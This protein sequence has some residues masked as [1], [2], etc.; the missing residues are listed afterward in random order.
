MKNQLRYP[1]GQHNKVHR[2]AE[3]RA[4]YDLETVHSIMNRSFV[5]HVSFQPDAEDP[6]PTT[7][8]MLGAMGNFA[9]PSAGLNEPQDC[10]IHG[11]ISARMANLSRKAMDDGL[12]G[13]PVC[14][15]VAKVDGLVLALSAFTHSCNYRSAVLFGH[16]ALVTD[17][18][19]KLW[20][21]ELLTNKIIPGRWDQVRQPPNKFELMQT[22]IL[23]VRVTSGSA[24]IRAGPPADDKED[25]QD[26]GVM[27]NVWSGYVPLVERMGQPIPSAYNQL[28]DV[29]EHVR[30]LQEGFNEEADAYNDKLVKQA[31]RKESYVG[32]FWLNAAETLI[33]ITKAKTKTDTNTNTQWILEAGT[34]DD[35]G[36]GMDRLKIPCDAIWLDI[37]CPIDKECL[38]MRKLLDAFG[39]KLIIIIDPHF[40]NTN[41]YNIVL[42]SNDITSRSKDDDIFEG[43]C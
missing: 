29:P 24:K 34:L 14:V 40:K 35:L 28:Q 1:A 7:I 12:P 41:G 9:Y 31:N 19:E 37:E 3:K 33:D 21:L 13:L 38:T 27:K 4:S 10:Y 11:Y 30:D 2:L 6:F 39:R 32:L 22:Q 5:F 16:A 43:H 25:V 20:A 18:S 17:E 36:D 8:P 26:S 42:K 15:S 23:R